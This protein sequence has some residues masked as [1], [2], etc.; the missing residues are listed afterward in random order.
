[1]FFNVKHFNDKNVAN[2]PKDD[3]FEASLTNV[4]PLI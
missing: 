1:M 4:S 2:K 3:H